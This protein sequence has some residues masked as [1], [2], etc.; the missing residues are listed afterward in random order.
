LTEIVIHISGDGSCRLRHGPSAVKLETTTPPEYGG[1]GGSFSAT[2]LVAA[3][4]GSCIATTLQA[5]SR[6]E[7]IADEAFAVRVVK[8]LAERPR[9]I[10]SLEVEIAADIELS[11]AQ[12]RKILAATRACPVHRS[13]HPDVL[14]TISLHPRV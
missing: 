8:T 9:R 13:L 14:V 11:D 7:G 1:A 5:V 6:R 3:G 12:R 4:L 10:E 2:D